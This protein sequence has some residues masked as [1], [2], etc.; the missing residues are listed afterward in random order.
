MIT[1][2]NIRTIDNPCN[3]RNKKYIPYTTST[4]L[5]KSKIDLKFSNNNS[6]ESS[7]YILEIKNNLIKSIYKSIYKSFNNNK[8]SE[9]NNYKHV[10]AGFNL[11]LKLL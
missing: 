9:I 8:N 7:S 5:T 10:K 4:D 3:T 11:T 2:L 1:L 6:Q